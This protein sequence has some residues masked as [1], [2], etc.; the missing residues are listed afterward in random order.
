MRVDRSSAAPPTVALPI[1]SLRSN[2]VAGL[3]RRHN[4]VQLVGYE[5]GNLVLLA[6]V[7]FATG[8]AGE[9]EAL[10]AAAF[11]LGSLSICLFD[12]SRR[13]TLL[14]WG[15]LWLTS[16]GL[17]LVLAGFP[18]T[19]GAVMLASLETARGGLR[20]LEGTAGT[21]GQ[22]RSIGWLANVVLAPYCRTVDALVIRLPQFGGFI[23]GRPFLTG[24]LIKLPLR[25]EFVLRKLLAGDGVGV[26]VGLLW[27][28]G[29]VAL[30][31][32]DQQLN[33]W[34]ERH[35]ADGELRLL[36]RRG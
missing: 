19:G 23:E 14:L 25:L 29:D 9:L 30:A 10:A 36:S 15:G 32:N 21:S 16:G 34:L 31:L 26:L 7:G 2:I 13:P 24:G 11:M 27:M 18:I 22:I 4:I 35:F 1:F 17:M 20:L 33:G 12:P 28:V 5:V 6:Q 3:C 8:H